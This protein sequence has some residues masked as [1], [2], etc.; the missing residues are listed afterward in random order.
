MNGIG[1]T[2]RFFPMRSKIIHHPTLF[3]ALLWLLLG[4]FCLR[5]IGQMLVAFWGVTF[6]PPM[7]AWYSG[8]IPYPWLLPIQIIII[9][10]YAKVCLD[11]SR[12]N[13]FFYTPRPSLGR[14][15]LIFGA[16][17]LTGM[18]GR[19]IIRMSLHP[20]ERWF[21]GAIP[22]VYHW[23]LAAFILLVGSY[24]WLQPQYSK[25]S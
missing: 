7:A 8:L 17:Y 10:I 4:L 14:G 13:G 9:I 22:I 25:K 3:A 6:L 15:L 24:H 19:Y 1:I 5:V 2:G 16:I 20:E 12:R 23:V 18:V 11:F 21:D